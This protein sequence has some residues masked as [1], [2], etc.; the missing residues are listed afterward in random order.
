LEQALNNLIDNAAKYSSLAGDRR[1]VLRAQRI[2]DGIAIE[3]EDNGPGIHQD[4]LPL[5]TEKF[6]RGRSAT[7]PGSGLG[8]AIVSRVVKNHGGALDI[9]SSAAG[10][11]VRLVLPALKSTP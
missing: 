4:D 2:S 3:I 9:R 6:Y 5:V 8:L 10:A 1:I 7:G 11:V